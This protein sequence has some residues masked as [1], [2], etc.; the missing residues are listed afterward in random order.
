MSHNDLLVADDTLLMDQPT[1][2]PD[3]DLLA[4]R[5]KTSRKTSEAAQSPLETYLR[6]INETALLTA[7]EELELATRIAQGDVR[8]RDRMV[9]ANL[10]LVVNIARGYTGKG[11]GLQDLIEEGNLGLLRAVE[12]F[13]PTVGTRFST[14]A[15]YW[16][17]QSIKRALIN[18]SKTIRIPAYMVELLSKWRRG[19]ARLSE[20]LGRTPTQEEIA[21]VLGLPKKKLPI[22]R[23]AIHINNSTPQSDQSESGWSLGDMVTDERLK[24]PD[25]A[26][27]DHD[28]LQHAMDL[29]EGLDE[30]EATVLKLRFGLDGC[31]PH[32][33]KEIGADLGLTR[34][35]VRQIETEALR[36]LADGLTDPRERMIG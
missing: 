1:A 19:T 22:I 20:E 27:L 13:D 5:R 12:G 21:R 9:R 4:D 16:I 26:L 35:R 8:A 31:E 32:T 15:S 18:S 24:A 33:L 11:L 34:E 10:R 14:Y 28:I 3:G 29:L 25:E 7:A 23:K 30:R 17:K 6:E 2:D 36:R